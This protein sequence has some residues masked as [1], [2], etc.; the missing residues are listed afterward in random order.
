MSIVP[1]FISKIYS[2]L[3]TR[4]KSD[5]KSYVNLMKKNGYIIG[6]SVIPEKE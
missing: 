4:N 2:V 3:V 1:T 6:I 5:Y